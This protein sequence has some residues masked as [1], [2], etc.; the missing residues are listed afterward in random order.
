MV[1]RTM[2]P[3]VHLAHACDLDFRYTGSGTGAGDLWGACPS[4]PRSGCFLRVRPGSL[5]QTSTAQNSEASDS[6]PKGNRLNRS[7][8][9]TSRGPPL[10]AARAAGPNLALPNR[11]CSRGLKPP[12]PS[13]RGDVAV[14]IAKFRRA[15]AEMLEPTIASIDPF[16]C[17]GGAEVP[18]LTR[19]LDGPCS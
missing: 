8:V 14:E 11:G 10:S 9:W 19:P 3:V 17:R 15:A 2:T 18:R 12:D 13:S 16:E 1:R 5:T 4:R 6:I 7:A